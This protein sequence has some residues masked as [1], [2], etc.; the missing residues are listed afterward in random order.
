MG[1]EPDIAKSDLIAQPCPAEPF[2]T[3]LDCETAALMRGWLLPIFTGASSW[4][5]LC[6][7]LQAKGYALAFRYGTLCLTDQHTGVSV[8]SLQSLGTSLRELVG[9]LGRPVVRQ[10]LNEPGRGE[11]HTSGEPR[12]PD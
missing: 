3:A 5:A 6:A 2:Y 7:A 12:K 4:P 11:L 8:C 10:T 9:R 1:A